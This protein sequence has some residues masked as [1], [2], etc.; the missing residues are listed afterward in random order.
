MEDVES[1]ARAMLGGPG[2]AHEVLPP[3][4][5][6]DITLPQTLRFGYYTSGNYFVIMRSR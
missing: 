3:V 2:A 1:G 5:Y 4:P 6:R